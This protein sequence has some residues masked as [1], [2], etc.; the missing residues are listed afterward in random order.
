M[1]TNA[2]QEGVAGWWPRQGLA[3]D[4]IER[5]L[6]RALEDILN[7]QDPATPAISFPGTS[8]W[9]YAVETWAEFAERHPNGIGC[10]TSGD[11]EKG[12]GGTQELEKEV[13]YMAGEMMRAKNPEEEVDGYIADGGTG[14]N[15]Q[16]MWMARNFHQG[17]D[18][19]A[20]IAIF[21]T[22]LTHCS[23]FKAA[24]VLGLSKERSLDRYQ[25]IS[26]PL[27]RD[28]SMNMD[29]LAEEVRQFLASSQFSRFIVVPTLGST[30]TGAADD[31]EKLDSIVEKYGREKF[32]VHLDAAQGGFVY[33]FLFPDKKICF[34]VPCVQSTVV[35]VHKMGCGPYP[36]ALFLCRK[37]LMRK[38]TATKIDYI[39]D[40]MDGTLLGSRSGAMA[41]AIWA[42]FHDFGWQGFVNLNQ[43]CIEVTT[44]LH[45]ELSKSPKIAGLTPPIINQLAFCLDESMQNEQGEKGRFPRQIE[46]DFCLA[47]SLHHNPLDTTQGDLVYWYKVPVMPDKQKGHFKQL[48]NLLER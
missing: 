13:I 36:S 12:F 21:V 25:I 24:D 18:P 22:E 19:Y 17:M 41:A 33:P 40:I 20:H 31:L 14:G 42:L 45:G 4:K 5:R 16:G 2:I 39:N 47:G 15:I 10:H 37:G 28:G 9:P 35:D 27:N 29:Q 43:R 46:E 44:W 26:L 11:V 38:T 6:N 30:M 3:R 8:V 34:D 32:W 23:V 7:Y 1:A 48:L